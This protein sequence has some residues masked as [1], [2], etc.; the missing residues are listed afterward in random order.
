MPKE[1]G[2]KPTTFFRWA[3]QLSAIAM[4]LDGLEQWRDIESQAVAPRIMQTVA[5]LDR[6]I[7]GPLAARWQD[8]RERYV[9]QI[10]ALLLALRKRAA[11]RSRR[12]TI[13][14]GRARRCAPACREAHHAA[15]AESVAGGAQRTG[16]DHSPG[17]NARHGVRRG[18]LWP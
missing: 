6:G 7:T 3:E 16:C 5:A 14:V 10:D 9:Q 2:A 18:M 8:F 1:G 11:D 15:L 17:R 12:R 4:E 13:A